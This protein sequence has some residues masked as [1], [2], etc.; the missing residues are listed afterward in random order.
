[1]GTLDGLITDIAPGARRL[2]PL[3][4]A[5]RPALH[6]L[7]GLVPTAVGTL[8]AAT[9][10][11][12]RITRL[13]DVGGPFLRRLRPVTGALS[14]MVACLRP[15]SPEAGAAITSA[16]SWISTYAL[17][18]PRGTPGVTFLGAR[19]RE[20]VRQHGVRAMPQASASSVASP[21]NTAQ[22]VA[23]TGKQY[24][25]PRPPGYS[26]GEPWFL[27]SC[28]VTPAALDPSKDPESRP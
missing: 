25:M 8:T 14:P 18:R 26:V 13:L 3:A 12:P 4:A 9:A 22:F 19:Q 23:A 20:F 15:Y 7:R 2:R 6:E 16:G 27:P 28:G 5:L 21:L 1:V 11:A 17:E 24:A 10:A